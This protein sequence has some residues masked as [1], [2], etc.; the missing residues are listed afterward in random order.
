MSSD[1][2]DDFTEEVERLCSASW[3]SVA[4]RGSPI[5]SEV[6]SVLFTREDRGA[7][8]VVTFSLRTPD[9]S[10]NQS[11]VEVDPVPTDE[12]S[13][14]LGGMGI[15][16]VASSVAMDLVTGSVRKAVASCGKR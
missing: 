12:A 10:W 2:F 4:G 13:V 3:R 8:W 6:N 11:R 1:G 14:G 9:G 16:N 7:K 5:V 15:R